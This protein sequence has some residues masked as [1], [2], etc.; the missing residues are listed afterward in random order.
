MSSRQP[1]SVLPPQRPPSFISAA[2]G[3]PPPMPLIA[4]IKRIAGLHGDP[5]TAKAHD[6][7]WFSHAF[8]EELITPEEMM[9]VIL[10][11]QPEIFLWGFD[12]LFK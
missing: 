6:N 10:E 4:S 1:R 9:K 5:Y 7:D 12:F 11:N 8:E 2:T 3:I